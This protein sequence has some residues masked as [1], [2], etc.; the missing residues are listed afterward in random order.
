MVSER[1][2]RCVPMHLGSFGMVLEITPGVGLTIKKIRIFFSGGGGGK[3]N[4]GKGK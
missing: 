3:G 2:P 1:Y 4:T